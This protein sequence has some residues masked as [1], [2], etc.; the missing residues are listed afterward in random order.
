MLC[1]TVFDMLR[2]KPTDHGRVLSGVLFFFIVVVLSSRTAATAIA[3]LKWLVSLRDPSG[4]ENIFLGRFLQVGGLVVL[5]NFSVL[6]RF[7]ID[8]NS[9][10]CQCAMFLFYYSM[11]LEPTIV[12]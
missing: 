2:T 10:C 4:D 5:R 9:R 3:L 1:C 12:M 7:K 8:V 6:T 11:P